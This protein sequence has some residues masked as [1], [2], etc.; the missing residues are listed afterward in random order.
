MIF[1]FGRKKDMRE[2]LNSLWNSEKVTKATTE[3]ATSILI[4]SIIDYQAVE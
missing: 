2:S 3:A 4:A 1:L